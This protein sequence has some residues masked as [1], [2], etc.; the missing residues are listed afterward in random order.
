MSYLLKCAE[1][2]LAYENVVRNALGLSLAEQQVRSVPRIPTLGDADLLGKLRLFVVQLHRVVVALFGPRGSS[3]SYEFVAY[4]KRVRCAHR[5]FHWVPVR[6]HKAFV[7]CR[8]FG[9][10]NGTQAHVCQSRFGTQ[11]S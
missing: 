11:V 4:V 9:E 8:L 6:Q 7:A 1:C 2:E 3:V 10:Q 5:R